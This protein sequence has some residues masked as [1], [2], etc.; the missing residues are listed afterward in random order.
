MA[1]A[2]RDTLTLK[3]EEEGAP[4]RTRC[5]APCVAP[6]WRLTQALRDAAVFA[7]ALIHL[8]KSRAV[9]QCTAEQKAYADCVRGRSLT[10][11]RASSRR[12]GACAARR[13]AHD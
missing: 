2:L 6:A 8:M 3:K 11:V 13:F 1:S 7:A 9:K 4:R 10:I 12:C 5:G